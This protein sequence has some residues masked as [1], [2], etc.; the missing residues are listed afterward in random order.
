LSS[1]LRGILQCYAIIYMKKLNA[2]MLKSH[3]HI[4]QLEKTQVKF[5]GELKDV[6]I[7]MA[8]HPKLVQ[9]INIIVVDIP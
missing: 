9:V 3:K 4:I 6:M 5:I 8:M 2:V 1:R 7:R